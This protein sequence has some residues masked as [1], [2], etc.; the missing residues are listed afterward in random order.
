MSH[1][2]SRSSDT[3]SFNNDVIHHCARIRGE[4]ES[5]PIVERSQN[6]VLVQPNVVRHESKLALVQ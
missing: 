5:G 1:L 6:M 2:S 4:T 3:D